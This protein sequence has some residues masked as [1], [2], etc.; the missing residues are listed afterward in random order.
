MPFRFPL[1]A[2][3]RLRQSLEHQQELWLRA[4]NQ[5]VGRVRHLIE[6]LETR[7]NEK[8]VLQAQ[9][10]TSGMTAAEMRFGLLYEDALKEKRHALKQELRRLEQLRDQQQKVFQTARRERETLES[11]RDEQRRFYERE[12][13]RREQRQQDDLFL[14]RQVY[15][16][17]VR[18]RS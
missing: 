14:V 11:L 5:Q 18:P 16:R 8:R 10:L 4:A 1:E 12:T 15:S 13:L 9:Q 2:V 6:Q 17:R 3:F 7:M